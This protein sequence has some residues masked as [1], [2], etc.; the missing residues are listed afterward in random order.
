MP[1][2]QPYRKILICRSPRR[3]CAVGT[4][5]S[6]VERTLGDIDLR[7]GGVDNSISRIV[8]DDN[9]ISEEVAADDPATGAEYEAE[10]HLK[11]GWQHAG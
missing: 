10:H 4:S 9:P 8:D 1:L 6:V 3:R 7:F 11:H 2:D 5:L